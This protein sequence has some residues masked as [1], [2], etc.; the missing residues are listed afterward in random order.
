MKNR[1]RKGRSQK[2]VSPLY[3]LDP[4]IQTEVTNNVVDMINKIVAIKSQNIENSSKIAQLEQMLSTDEN[5]AKSVLNITD[6]RLVFIK[7][8]LLNTFN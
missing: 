4:S 8:Y 1:T 3:K 2:S 5:I 7:N 6:N